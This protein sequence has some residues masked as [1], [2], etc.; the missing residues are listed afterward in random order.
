[1]T[2]TVLRRFLLPALLLLGA[3]APAHG[4]EEGE[5]VLSPFFVVK[6]DA[7]SVAA[8]PLKRTDVRAQ[9]NGAIADVIVTQTYTNEG[10]RPIDARYVFPGSTRAAVHGMTIAVDDEVVTAKIRQREEA[11]QEF[12]TAR[13]QGKSASLL[14]Q[15][16]PNVFTMS[17]A[18]VMPGDEVVVSLHYTELLV[19]EDGTYEFVYPTVVAPRYAGKGVVGAA[20]RWEENP[21]LAGS[22]PP[23]TAFDIEVVLSTALPLH[24]VVSAT[25]AVDVSWQG[26]SMAE[27]RLADPLDFGGD[28]DYVLKYRLSGEQIQSGLSLYEG[29]DENFFLLMVQPPE[30][31]DGLQIPPREY[32]FILDVSG[33][34]GGFPLDTAKAVIKDLIARLRPDD[35]FNIVMFAGGSRVLAP[36]SLPANDEN[37]T[38][39]LWVIDNEQGGGGTE[40]V[41]A[42]K[43]ALGLPGDER[44]SRTIAVITDGL[45]VAEQETFAL[46]RS[47]LNNA[48]VFSFGIGSSVNRHL[49]EGIA[50][51]G[52]GEPFVVTEAAEAP[53][54]AARFRDYIGAPVLTNI[55]VSFRGFDAYDIE[56]QIVPDLFAR[57]P[58]LVMGK[59]RGRRTGEIE[60]SGLRATGSYVQ[61]FHLRDARPQE[62]NSALRS[63][64]ARQMVARLSDDNEL[65]TSRDLVSRITQLGLNYSLLTRFTSF[66]A[67]VETVRNPEGSAD[68]VTQHLALA[69]GL[70]AGAVGYSSGS[71]PDLRVLLMAVAA[72]LVVCALRHFLQ[73]IV[74]S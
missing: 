69:R 70:S 31:V 74:S 24:D 11:K 64:W 21:Y 58:I 41:P 23:Q 68:P 7:S 59:Y 34:M 17:V 4:D 3:A 71:E 57:R 63:L 45:V 66:V 12:E 15:Q 8:F 72:L 60:V 40:L 13:K 56:P 29:E 18:N 16:R 14:E 20:P 49:I 26:H 50:R 73:A 54:A 27:V 48:N 1:M 36:E 61:R 51:A 53:D 46:I 35:L 47:H 39:A 5:R 42:L 37:I 10:A 67:V 38:Q 25:H 33:S 32:I 2:P 55:G 6:G 52:Q 28:R 44:Y 43:T 62:E 65:G 19:P 22:G 9:I 30:R